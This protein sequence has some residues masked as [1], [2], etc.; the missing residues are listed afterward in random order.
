MKTYKY[1]KTLNGWN[2]DAALYHVSPSMVYH[3]WDENN[4]MINIKIDYV[5]VSAAT[6]PYS[7]PET[8]I[9]PASH[10]SIKTNSPISFQNLMGSFKGELNHEQAFSN[11]GYLFDPVYM[12]ISNTII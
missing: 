8:F 6:A 7:G 12:N 9:F 11:A 1:I 3:D 2:G 5:I 4:K 10:N